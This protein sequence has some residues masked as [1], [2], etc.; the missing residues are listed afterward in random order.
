[1]TTLRTTSMLQR[2]T[3]RYVT[4]F[5]GAYSG[6]LA[7]F[8]FTASPATVPVRFASASVS[9]ER[10]VLGS[11]SSLWYTATTAISVAPAREAAMAKEA[12]GTPVAA[13]S[14]EVQQAEQAQ[15]QQQQLAEQS[16]H[17]TTASDPQQRAV[18]ID[19]LGVATPEAIQ[20][21]RIAATADVEPRNRIRAINMLSTMAGESDRQ[22]ALQ[23]LELARQDADPRVAARATAAHESLI[24]E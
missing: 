12:G 1:M 11:A 8:H 13:N 23:I 16:L 20:A 15:Q 24:A 14:M 21:L 19:M 2:S 5:V 22:T 6:F 4:L 3:W 7:Y 18:A 17:A 10:R 9:Q